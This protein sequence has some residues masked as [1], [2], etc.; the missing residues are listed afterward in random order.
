MTEIKCRAKVSPSCYHGRSEAGIYPD[1]AD[2]DGTYNEEDGTVVCDPCYIAIG[3]PRRDKIE[4]AIME[5][6]SVG[7]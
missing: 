7:G 4:K 6:R 3:Q 2:D 5:A 1:G